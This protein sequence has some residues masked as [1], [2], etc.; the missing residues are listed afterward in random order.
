MLPSRFECC[1]H[2]CPSGQV[3][4]G[5]EPYSGDQA[6]DIN[7]HIQLLNCNVDGTKAAPKREWLPLAMRMVGFHTRDKANQT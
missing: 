1:S 2:Q 3:V 7:T 5:E 6:R 4:M